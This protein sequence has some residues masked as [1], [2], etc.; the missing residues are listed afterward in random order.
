MTAWEYFIIKSCQISMARD[1]DPDSRVHWA[2]MGPTWVLPAQMGPMLAPWTL[3]SGVK[4]IHK[5]QV[6][7][8][9]ATNLPNF[10][11]ACA[12]QDRSGL[13]WQVLYCHMCIQKLHGDGK[14]PLD[15]KFIKISLVLWQYWSDYLWHRCLDYTIIIASS[16]E[17]SYQHQCHV[18]IIDY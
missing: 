16:R 12:I 8:S 9:D 13:F 15:P 5:H 17:S 3:L 10:K 7:S 11:H 2:N 14:Y 1:G 18:R 4:N 6:G